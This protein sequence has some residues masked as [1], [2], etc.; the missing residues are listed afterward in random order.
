MA[1]NPYHTAAFAATLIDFTTMYVQSAIARVAGSAGT[2]QGIAGDGAAQE[3]GFV[4][5]LGHFS[6]CCSAAAEYRE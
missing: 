2:Q 1:V 5:L 3:D 6:D 4:G